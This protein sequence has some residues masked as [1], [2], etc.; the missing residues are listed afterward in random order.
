MASG[1]LDGFLSQERLDECHDVLT[2][3][4]LVDQ[5]LSHDA[6]GQIIKGD[7][8]FE[9]GPDPRAHTTYTEVLST[10]YVHHDDIAI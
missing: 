6:P 5:V 10:L 1:D 8:A 3:C 2:A 9:H 7:W 4:L